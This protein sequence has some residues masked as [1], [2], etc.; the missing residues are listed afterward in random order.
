MDTNASQPIMRVLLKLMIL[1]ALPSVCVAIP[2]LPAESH[3]AQVSKGE[4]SGNTYLNSAL[5]FRYQ[6][7]AGWNVSDQAARTEHQFGW[8]DDPSGRSATSQCSKKLLFATKH[9]EEMRINGFDP[10][11]VV[12]AVDPGCF[13]TIA[14][15]NSADNREAARKV[16]EQV[17]DHLL[18]PPLVGKTPSSVHPFEYD[19]RVVLEFSQSFSLAIHELGGRGVENVLSSVAVTQTAQYWVM[20]IFAAASEADLGTLK[21]TKI[22]FDAQPPQG[23]EPK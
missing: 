14:F 23:T 1:A 15:P 4:V 3:I 5:G 2:P 8:K 17:L 10:M 19:G 16:V 20:W 18:T 9:S 11:V 12:I 6:F 13:P 22:F 21:S 7:P